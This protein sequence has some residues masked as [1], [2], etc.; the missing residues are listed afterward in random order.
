M[1]RVSQKTEDE[2]GKPQQRIVSALGIARPATTGIPS[3]FGAPKINRR[4]YS[5]QTI[6]PET[7]PIISKVPVPPMVHTISVYSRLWAR[8]K[9]GDH[10]ELTDRQA[11]GLVA[12][13]KKAGGK[14]AVRRLT[15]AKGAPREGIKGVW[16]LD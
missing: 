16:R 15:D 8:M 1:P 9:K 10:V 11:H 13:A 7:V 6:D 2:Q 12:H 5:R 14:V 4:N 3:V